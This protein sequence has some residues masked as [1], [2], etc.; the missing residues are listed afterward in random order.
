MALECVHTQRLGMGQFTDRFF[1]TLESMN[2]AVLFS[3]D[4]LGQFIHV[5]GKLLICFF[6]NGIYESWVAAGF[7][8]W[9][10]G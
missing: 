7:R 6:G 1:L 5:R 3:G 8:D 10:L 4:E 2:I 9:R